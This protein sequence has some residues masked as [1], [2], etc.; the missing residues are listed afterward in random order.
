MIFRRSEGD[1]Q[2]YEWGFRTGQITD[3]CTPVFCDELDGYTFCPYV[4]KVKQ[5]PLYQAH[6]EE[7]VPA[8]IYYIDKSNGELAG[9]QCII[10]EKTKQIYVAEGTFNAYWRS[11][12]KRLCGFLREN[13][14]PSLSHSAMNKYVDLSLAKKAGYDVRINYNF[15]LSY[16]KVEKEIDIEEQRLQ[17]K[18]ASAMDDCRIRFVFDKCD[19]LVH[20]KSCR[21]VQGIILHNFGAT[22]TVPENR[23]VCERCRRSLYIRKAIKTDTKH[24]AWYK[25]FF[26]RGWVSTD[27]LEKYLWNEAAEL[28]MDS[29]DELR[30]KYREDTWII[31][32]KSE[33]DYVL[34]HNNYEMIGEKE[35]YITSGFHEQSRFATRLSKVMKYIDGYDWN[36]HFVTEEEVLSN[37]VCANDV[38]E[39]ENALTEVNNTAKKS[40]AERMW[41][42]WKKIMMRICKK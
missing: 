13:G 33:E 38:L 29:P 5:D 4:G 19:D 9:M 41:T 14:T 40:L 10:V 3:E 7:A 21:L 35:R 31:L 32:M 34:L 12:S 20:D 28:H 11:V 2:A 15:Q 26:D 39:D 17:S 30:I 24:F 22:E 23:R 6:R 27:L 25:H 42:W 16:E 37:G 8:K 18:R 1:R 36:K